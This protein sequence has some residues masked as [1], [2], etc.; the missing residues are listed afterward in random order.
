MWIA[1]QGHPGTPLYVEPLELAIYPAVQDL[2][3][4]LQ[5]LSGLMNTPVPRHALIEGCVFSFFFKL[6]YFL[7]ELIKLA[8]DQSDR[9]AGISYG[10]E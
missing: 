8:R 7:P 2:L 9:H 3:H 10:L 6:F 1:L 4:L 5:F